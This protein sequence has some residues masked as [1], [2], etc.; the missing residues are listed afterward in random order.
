[1]EPTPT[2]SPLTKIVVS[3]ETVTLTSGDLITLDPQTLNNGLF[4]EGDYSYEI[5]PLSS[6]G[7]T[8]SDDGEFTAG[9][10]TSLENIEETI[11]VTDTA[12]QNV[13]GFVTIIIAGREQSSST[14]ELSISPLSATLASEDSMVFAAHNVGKGCG[15]GIYEWKVN[16]KIGSSINAQGLYR[17]GKNRSIQPALDIIMVTDTVNKVSSDVLITV[18]SGVEAS[19]GVTAGPSNPKL[20][21]V[22]ESQTFPTILAVLIIFLIVFG[23][24]FLR[25]I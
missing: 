1:M 25:K 14:C 17:A 4:V 18:L 20:T 12:N 19:S 5:T 13:S 8:M 7:S 9:T 10:N 3:P 22:S 24:L 21:D 23:I 15:E 16:S 6:I 11:K 2:E